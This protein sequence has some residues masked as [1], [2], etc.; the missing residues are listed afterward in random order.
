MLHFQHNCGCDNGT[1]DS[2]SAALSHG[3]AR[4]RLGEETGGGREGPP[5]TDFV[6]TESNFEEVVRSFSNSARELIFTTFSISTFPNGTLA[7]H[8]RHGMTAF[9]V[10]FVRHL[11]R[12]GADGDVLLVAL[13]EAACGPTRAFGLL[14]Y[15]DALPWLRQAKVYFG[16]QVALKWLYMRKMVELGFH[17]LFLDNDAA[18]LQDPLR[19]WDRSFDLQALSDARTDTN[20]DLP[21]LAKD[22]SCGVKYQGFPFPCASTGVLY[23]RATD[24]TRT[25]LRSF[26]ARVERSPSKWEQASFQRAVLPFLMQVG[27]GP[28]AL[29]FRLL[30]IERFHNV[31][32]LALRRLSG[33]AVDSV[34]VHCGKIKGGRAKQLALESAGLWR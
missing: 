10:N 14:C 22:L 29:R 16:R 9:N 19:H 4:R 28:P 5:E 34:V 6:I 30:P 13:S 21:A 23:V 12:A 31:K 26:A 33:R 7:D 24:A 25:F 20:G 1:K 8:P 27:G 17:P 32:D 2:I 3:P 18:A 15:V 11:V